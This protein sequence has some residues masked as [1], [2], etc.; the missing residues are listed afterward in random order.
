MMD[1]DASI[2]S[3]KASSKELAARKGSTYTTYAGRAQNGSVQVSRKFDT[4]FFVNKSVQCAPMGANPTDGYYF[5]IFGMEDSL[6][7]QINCTVTI[8][9]LVK[10]WEL[11]DLSA[12]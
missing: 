1:D 6:T 7:S 8:S 11:K 5:G 9:Y 4:K 2:A 3:T 10:M 12:Q